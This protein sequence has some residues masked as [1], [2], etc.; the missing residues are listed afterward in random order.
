MLPVMTH[1]SPSGARSPESTAA[2]LLLLVALLGCGEL[3]ADSDPPGGDLRSPLGQ[4]A[5]TDAAAAAS[6]SD[7]G[8]RDPEREA[9][10]QLCVDE[11]NRYRATVGADGYTVLEQYLTSIV[12]AAATTSGKAATQRSGR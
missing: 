7:A 1:A 3:A 5:S 12:G 8:A 9:L 4:E 11:I 10:R 2:I 6:T